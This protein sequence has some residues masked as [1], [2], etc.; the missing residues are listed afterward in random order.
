MWR[1]LPCG[2]T[3]TGRPSKQTAAEYCEAQHAKLR[4]GY[5]M[6][7]R[8]K[9]AERLRVSHVEYGEVWKW[10]GKNEQDSWDRLAVSHCC[11]SAACCRSGC[12][13][14]T[15]EGVDTLVCKRGQGRKSRRV[16]RT[17]WLG[18]KAQR[19]CNQ[20]VWTKFGP[21]D[22]AA[23]GQPPPSCVVLLQ[24]ASTQHPPAAPSTAAA[25]PW[26]AA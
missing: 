2:I 7:E 9:A 1:V 19:A 12:C 14:A 25:P 17:A 15:V 11:R 24:Q 18:R 21:Q 26:C 23:A 5:G 4:C 6:P 13:I 16:G 22:C 20:A 8:N 10:M 3:V